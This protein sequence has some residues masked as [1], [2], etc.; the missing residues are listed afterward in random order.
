M[1]S[2]QTTRPKVAVDGWLEAPNFMEPKVHSMV[3]IA[4]NNGA[5]CGLA[6]CNALVI[7]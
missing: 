2:S 1:L 4:V 5:S 7:Q 6:Y 3:F